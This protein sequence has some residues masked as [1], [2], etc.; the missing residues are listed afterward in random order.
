M[1]IVTC[2]HCGEKVMIEKINCSKFCHG[3]MKKTGKQIN[4]HSDEKTCI[5]LLKKKMI[6]GCGK[7]FEIE[8]IGDNYI[9]K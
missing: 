1:I 6:Y 9:A 4:A 7:G 3:V 8:K 5:R 2:P